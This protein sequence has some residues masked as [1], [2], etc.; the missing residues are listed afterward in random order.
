MNLQL[1]IYD[2]RQIR[3][4]TN[5]EDITYFRDTRTNKCFAQTGA[6]DQS[7]LACVPCDSAVLA[8]IAQQKDPEMIKTS[9]LK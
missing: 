5:T 8:I 3:E 2:G 7:T 6:Y 9:M 1:D 4:N